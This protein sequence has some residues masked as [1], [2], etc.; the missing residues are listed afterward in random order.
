MRAL[1]K[2][3]ISCITYVAIYKMSKIYA[4]V[5][6]SFCEEKNPAIRKLRTFCNSAEMY[7]FLLKTGTSREGKICLQQGRRE[8]YRIW[9]TLNILTNANSSTDTK[10]D[11]NLH[12]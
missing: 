1:K 9:E 5:K 12:V 11:K 10:M 3:K 4:L 7:S 2:Y 6:E 8:K